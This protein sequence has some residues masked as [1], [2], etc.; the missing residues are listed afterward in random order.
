MSVVSFSDL[1]YSHKYPESKKVWK[2]FI[3]HPRVKSA[4]TIILLGDIF[5]LMI[6]GKSQYIEYYQDF[7]QDL[8]AIIE[9]GQ[10]IIYVE[11]NHDFHLERVFSIFIKK[12]N[13]NPDLFVYKKDEF[14]LTI[15]GKKILFCHGDLVDSTNDA[16]KK[17][18]SIYRNKIFQFLTNHMLPFYIIKKV[19][20][21][22]SD[23]SKQRN[24]RA[25]DYEK[26]KELYRHG[27][28]SI[29]EENNID[30]LVAGHTHI[31]D[32]YT[33]EYGLYINNGFPLKDGTFI[34][35]GSS[36]CELV[37]LTGSYE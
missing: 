15:E 7:F 2:L 33:N 29:L 36:G 13:L 31:I 5:D 23:D 11:G 16:F 37:S 32:N 1:H 18:K 14:T 8:R 20:E 19:G 3:N 26:S 9:N 12:Y 27:A 24:S 35:V 30:Y 17:W 21:K 10:K 22:A 6:G 4:H 28:I 25:F 34:E